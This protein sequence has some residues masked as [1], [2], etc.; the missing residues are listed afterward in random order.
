MTVRDLTI[1]GTSHIAKQSLRK[2]KMT[3]EKEKP[4]IVAV[5]LDKKRAFS[6]LYSKRSHLSI[7]HI[8]KIGLK[9]FV[10]SLLASWVQKKLGKMVGVMPGSEMKT[11]M[12]TAMKNKM[13]IAL[14]DRDIEITMKRFSKKITWREKFR[15]A[16]DMIK[17]LVFRKNAAKELGFDFNLNKVPEKKVI[18]KLIEYVEKRYPNV[19]E[20]LIKERNEIM[21]KNLAK[22]MKNEPGK[23][24]IAVVGAGHEEEMMRLVKKELKQGI[25][26]TVSVG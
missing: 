4:D 9:G 6:L 19:Y 17:G 10:F 26:Y 3:I 12:K 21:A 23:K 13:K 25:S 2:V 15:F 24:I 1:I 18:K 20:V 11:A 8:P 7:S 16:G 5:E 22:I 14:I